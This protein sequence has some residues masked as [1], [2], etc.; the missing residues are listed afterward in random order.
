MGSFG[1]AGKCFIVTGSAS[2][3]G[4]E[5]AKLLLEGGAS[6][7]LADVNKKGLEEFVLSLESAVQDRVLW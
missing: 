3:I 4:L 6:V 2:G 1:L 5:T 7:A